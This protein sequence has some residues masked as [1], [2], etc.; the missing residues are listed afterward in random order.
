[1][2]VR[3]PAGMHVCKYVCD[4]LNHISNPMLVGK[5]SS[6]CRRLQGLINRK[7]DSVKPR[8]TSGKQSPG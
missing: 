2:N 7:L 6:F 8:N 3:M 4:M 5:N 1:M